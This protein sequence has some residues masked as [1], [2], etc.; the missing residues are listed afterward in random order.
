MFFSQ[1]KFIVG[2]L[3]IHFLCQDAF[4]VMNWGWGWGG[5]KEK[6]ERGEGER[7][8]AETETPQL[9]YILKLRY[10]TENILSSESNGLLKFRS[11][12][13]CI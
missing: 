7:G 10:S 1:E 2:H 9:S 5:E 13:N 12:R 8:R 6:N 3:T 4:T 11:N